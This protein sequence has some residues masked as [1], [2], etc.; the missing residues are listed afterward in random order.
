VLRRVLGFCSRTISTIVLYRNFK[1]SVERRTGH[2]DGFCGR[3]GCAFK[4]RYQSPG[5]KCRSSSVCA[6]AVWVSES[7]KLSGVLG[8][9]L[10]TW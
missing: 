8:I 6:V 3:A 2:G 4:G 9:C 5:S 1:A 10:F 7:G